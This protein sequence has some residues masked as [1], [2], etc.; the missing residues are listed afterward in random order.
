MEKLAVAG[1]A[2]VPVWAP[3]TAW[4]LYVVVAPILLISARIDWYSWF[5]AP[6]CEVFSVPLP[7]SVASV[8]ARFSRLLT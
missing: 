4:P 8:T 3:K 6:D 7:A 5:A 2:A 1:A